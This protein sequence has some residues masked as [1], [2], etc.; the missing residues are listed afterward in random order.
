MLY[1]TIVKY[2]PDKSFGFILSDVGY[3]VFFHISAL[4]DGGKT[5][6]IQLG[7]PV[8]YE[9]TPRWEERAKQA[10][11]GKEPAE[12]ARPLQPAAKLVE[13]IDKLPGASLADLDEDQ[14]TKKHPRARHKKPTWRR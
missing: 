6:D 11:S 8:K 5:A 3:D 12:G 14:Q 1:G 9:L 10:A 2:F 13:L 4:E 7:Q